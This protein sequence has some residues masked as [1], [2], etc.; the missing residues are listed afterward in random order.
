MVNEEP[1]AYYTKVDRELS[2][3]YKKCYDAL[4]EADATNTSPKQPDGVNYK[5]WIE[6]QLIKKQAEGLSQEYARLTRDKESLENKLADFELLAGDA[7]KK[8][9]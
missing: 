4:L 5:V 1:M 9:K 8:S 3:L 7:V 2:P 6:C